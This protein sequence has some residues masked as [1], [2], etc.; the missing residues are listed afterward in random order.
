MANAFP[1]RHR[2]PRMS[3]LEC[4]TA[5]AFPVVC[6]AVEGWS[7]SLGLPES[8]FALRIVY[9][10]FVSSLVLFGGGLLMTFIMWTSLAGI[11][12]CYMAGLFW[13]NRADWEQFRRTE[14]AIELGVVTKPGLDQVCGL[15][16]A[17]LLLWPV[18]RLL[19]A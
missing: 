13:F 17:A 14:M 6:L 1:S 12:N 18:L 2:F 9:W 15:V 16:A 7:R 10:T 4:L 3:P 11:W 19:A 5:L 8:Y